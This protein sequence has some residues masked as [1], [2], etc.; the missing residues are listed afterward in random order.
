M[1]TEGIQLPMT[2]ASVPSPY[3]DG[4]V[5]VIDVS[6]LPR[7]AKYRGRAWATL[8]HLG[9]GHTHHLYQRGNGPLVAVEAAA[10]RARIAARKAGK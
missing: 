10:D 2:Q 3:G 6:D 4:L 5:P 9:N 1:S 7:G 8:A